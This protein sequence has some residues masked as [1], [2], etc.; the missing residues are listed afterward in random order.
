MKMFGICAECVTE[1]HW[2]NCDEQKLLNAVCTRKD[3]SV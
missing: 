3:K 1:N 2:T